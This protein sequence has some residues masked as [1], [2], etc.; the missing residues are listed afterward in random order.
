MRILKCRFSSVIDGMYVCMNLPLKN[1]LQWL[2]KKVK[3][4]EEINKIFT[5]HS[6]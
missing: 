6:K 4:N 1:N 2:K 5:I 3:I